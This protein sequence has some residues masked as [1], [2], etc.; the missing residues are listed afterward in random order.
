MVLVVGAIASPVEFSSRTEVKDFPPIM[1]L[2]D[3]SGSMS[4]FPDSRELS[5]N[6]YN[7]ISGMV[8]NIT[9]NTDNIELDL[10]SP[11]NTTS[12]GDAF[13]RNL[14]KSKGESNIIVLVSDGNNNFGRNPVDMAEAIGDTNSTIFV[15]K[16]IQSKN[17]VYVKEVFGDRKIPSKSEYDLLMTIGNTG[18]REVGY[19]LEVSVE[20]VRR[21]NKHFLQNEYEKQVQLKLNFDSPGVYQIKV[22]IKSVQ[23]NLTANNVYYKTV[24]VVDKPSVLII[25]SNVTSPLTKVLARLYN[26]DIKNS[27]DTDYSPFTCV[28]LDNIPASRLDRNRVNDLR[29]YVLKGNGLVV[30]GGKNSYEYGAYNNSFIENILPV[31][32][33][34]K[35]E[36]RR[37]KIAVLFLIDIS[38]S[39]EYG[40]GTDSKIDIEKALALNMIRNLDDNDTV[41]VIAFNTLPYVVSGMSPLGQKRADVEDRILRLKFVGGTDMV[42]SLESAIRMFKGYS[43]PKYIILLSD[44]VIPRSKAPIVFSKTS[45]LKEMDVTV[46]S[47][48]VGFDTDVQMMSEIARVGGGMY[49]MPEEY[50]RLKIQFGEKLEEDNPERIPIII[51]DHHHFIS[52]NL[53]GWNDQRPPSRG[54]NKVYEKSV[55][56]IPMT[57]KG[58]HPALAVWRF[59]LGRVASLM[60][61]NGIVWG[62]EIYAAHS[63]KLLSALSNWVIGDLEKNKD[64]RIVTEDAHLG[65][66]ITIDVRASDKPE[67]IMQKS[68]TGEGEELDLTRTGVESYRSIVEPIETG[69]YGIKATTSSGSDLSA[70]ALNYPLEYA[71]LG[72]NLEVLEKVAL[73]ANG[74]V[75]EPDEIE[76]LHKDILRLATLKATEEITEEREL[77]LY[78]VITALTIYFIDVVVRR[79]FE[80]YSLMM[81]KRSQ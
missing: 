79:I 27:L 63:G 59:G 76:Q 55:A 62:Q 24:E 16:P 29:D 19:D 30:V 20:G 7:G 49:F 12:I 81:S 69:F 10:F 60:L 31:K 68:M 57:T 36:D 40:Q 4:L 67:L 5:L 38:K 21:F 80:I 52:R 47:V 25:T 2:G 48:G 65:D 35:P 70:I 8:G 61:D 11:G 43:I 22:E 13:Y 9:G 46:Y 75:Y 78:F 56:Q 51:N 39:T 37:K 28:F 14:V 41:G 73:S 45:T 15:V 50:Q 42:P 71:D 44:G 66:K 58:G 34:E 17:D 64:V 6:V 77:W 1:V 3:S 74:R 53:P 18:F 32:S 26:L 33:S 23:D 54:Y 72:I